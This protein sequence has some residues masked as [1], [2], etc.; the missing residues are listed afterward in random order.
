[1]QTAHPIARKLFLGCT[2][3]RHQRLGIHAVINARAGQQWRN[4]DTIQDIEM[5]RDARRLRDWLSLRIR[6]YRFG[7]RC[8][9]RRPELVR[10]FSDPGN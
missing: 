2:L 7:S 1:M 4:F 8:F 5:Q 6:F 10:H 3:A 9:R